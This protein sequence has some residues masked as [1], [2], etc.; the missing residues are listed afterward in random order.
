MKKI[1]ILLTII[2]L[3]LFG[4]TNKID[5]LYKVI[6]NTKTIKDKINTWNAIA[7]EYIDINPDSSNYYAYKSKEWSVKI[8]YQYGEY[9]ALTTLGTITYLVGKSEEGLVFLLKSFPNIER[10]SK[11]DTS[12]AVRKLFALY[13]KI[14]GNNYYMLG[15]L[16]SALVKYNKTNKLYEKIG[17][18][19][20][21]ASS[22]LNIANIQSLKGDVN[23]T[24]T[25][26]FTVLKIAEQTKDLNL[27]ADCNNSIGKIFYDQNE[28]EKALVYFKQALKLSTDGNILTTMSVISFNISNVLLEKGKI[29]EALTYAE[30]SLQYAEKTNSDNAKARAMSVIGIIYEAQNKNDKSL[31]MHKKTLVIVEK[32]KDFYTTLMTYE[33][34]SKIYTK[35][36]NNSQSLYYGKK[37]LAIAND[38]KSPVDITRISGLLTKL[39]KKMGD[40]ENALV[41]KELSVAMNDSIISQK[42][43]KAL[44]SQ[45]FKYTYGKKALQDSLSYINER[46][47][48]Q[49]EN[50]SKLKVEQNKRI[51]LYVILGLSIILGSFI[52]NRFKVTQKQKGLIETQSKRLEI[53]HINLEEKTREVQDSIIYSKEIQNI[54]LKSITQS[55]NYF[56][57][58]ILYYKPKAVVSG[59]FYWYK[60]LDDNLYIVVGDCTGHGVPGAIISVLAI[61]SLEKVV[62]L[63][64]SIENLHEINELMNDEFK[65]YYLQEKHVS[66]GLDFSVICLNKPSRKLY[67]SGSGATILL[68]NK[69]NELLVEKF[70]SINIGGIYPHFYNPHTMCF[71]IDN[72]QAVY[73]Y[74]DGIVDQKG[75]LT[76]KKYSTRKLKNLIV[77]L[78]TNNAAEALAIIEKEF[79]DWKSNGAQIDD[80]T[81]LGIQFSS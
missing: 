57:D 28:K 24:L 15:N 14:V 19:K 68:K 76:H 67:L 30:K 6:K 72:L 8:N 20:G 55:E 48:V 41:M 42:N 60:E 78:S 56:N 12:Y 38:L 37:A 45:E 70:A 62:P 25:N 43:Q 39:Y 22:L 7:V 63:L 26:L 52:F 17:D 16:D 46:K 9:E 13:N 53:A 73:L 3:T 44:I 10:Y 40:F 66:I 31:E 11:K 47:I 61:Q 23:A 79:D 58:S 51:A 35:I 36:N 77:D 4:Q 18:K 27:T 81:F 65:Q 1:T 33:S 21:I 59:D 34:L 64:K 75:E 2:N 80:M 32:T 49:L 5:S 54:F 71:D 69:Q 50:K 29:D 74:T